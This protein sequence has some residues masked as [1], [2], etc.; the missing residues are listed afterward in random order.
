MKLRLTL[1][2]Y[3]L[4]WGV[5]L[6]LVLLYLW[7]RGRRDPLY[8]RHLAE[9]FGFY[10]RPLPQ[11][12]IWVHAVS[13]GELRSAVALIRAM[14]GRGDRVVITT[15]T[16]AGAAMPRRFSPGP[17]QRGRWPSSG[18]P[19]TCAGACAGSSGPAARRSA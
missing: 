11:G 7:R 19:S 8:R 3:A 5:L 16:P 2:L 12:A 4:A 15:F 6:P 17:S 10:R 13:L 14:L 1:A 18:C 9:R